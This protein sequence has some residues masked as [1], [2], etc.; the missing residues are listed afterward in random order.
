[1]LKK[2]IDVRTNHCSTA[3]YPDLVTE[4]KKRT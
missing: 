4:L 1:M 3:D 2:H